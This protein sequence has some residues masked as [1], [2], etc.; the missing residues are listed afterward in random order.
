MDFVKYLR[1]IHEHK[2]CKF[3]STKKKHF[4]YAGYT[5]VLTILPLDMKF[6]YKLNKKCDNIDPQKF[7]GRKYLERVSML[8]NLIYCLFMYIRIMSGDIILIYIKKNCDVYVS[9]LFK[10]IM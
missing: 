1:N 10:Y 3:R 5:R 2:I 7:F 6:G 4:L 9:L 8:E